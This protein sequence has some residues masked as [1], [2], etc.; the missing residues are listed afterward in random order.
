MLTYH[1]L[2]ARR[3][4]KHFTHACLFISLEE[5]FPFYQHGE[6]ARDH[7]RS[8]VAVLGT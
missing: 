1:F 5:S 8:M 2:S 7:E 4:S 3:R 6:G